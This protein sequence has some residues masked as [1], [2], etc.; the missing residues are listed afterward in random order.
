MKSNYSHGT[1][2]WRCHGIAMGA[3]SIVIGA[4]GRDITM[5]AIAWHVTDCHEPP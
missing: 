4:H 2:A 1:I 3:H 5:A